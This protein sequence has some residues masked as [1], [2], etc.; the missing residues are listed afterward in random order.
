MKFLLPILI[1]ATIIT[2][3]N[4]ENKIADSGP[5][6]PIDSTSNTAN[7]LPVK[8]KEIDIADTIKKLGGYS[9]VKL[10]ESRDKCRDKILSALTGQVPT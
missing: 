5:V 6:T 10:E 8:E 4:N 2:S 1:G 9:V 7:T 3:C